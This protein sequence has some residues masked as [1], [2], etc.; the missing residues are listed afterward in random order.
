LTS[1]RQQGSMLNYTG[2]SLDR[3]KQRS[4]NRGQG[5]RSEVGDPQITQITQITWSRRKGTGKH[6]SEGGNSWGD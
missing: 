6:M 3:R 2:K 4:E 1:K 5:Q